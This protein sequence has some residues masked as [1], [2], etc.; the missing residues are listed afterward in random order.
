MDAL[1]APDWSVY[2]LVDPRDEQIRYVGKSVSV[3]TRVKAHMRERGTTR[4]IRWLQSL[5]R[6]EHREKI[7]QAALRRWARA[8][9]ETGTA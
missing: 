2:A 6:N 1:T 4:K 7:R 5:V 3:E 8:R 9:M